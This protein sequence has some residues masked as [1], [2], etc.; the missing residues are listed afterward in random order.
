LPLPIVFGAGVVL[1]VDVVLVFAFA[2]RL[3]SFAARGGAA[4]GFVLVVVF[5]LAVA[6]YCSGGSA[7][8][9]SL[10]K[11]TNATVL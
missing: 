10:R 7:G 6:A 3:S 11:N 1:T 2:F 4:V 5:V 8:L 9:Y